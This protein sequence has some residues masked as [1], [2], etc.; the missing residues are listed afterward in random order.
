MPPRAHAPEP[1]S[2]ADDLRSRS[3]AALVELLRLRPDLA[4]PSPADLT[5]L[6]ARAATRASVQR[7]LDRLAVAQL[8][9]V[10]VLAAL[11]EPVTE[12]D[13]ARLL[14]RPLAEAKRALAE[15]RDQALVW[16]I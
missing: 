14:G 2:L 5:A 6:A 16:G 8:Q 3:D 11:P 12:A 9:V 7:A 10:E 4:T 13:A 15:L 1:R